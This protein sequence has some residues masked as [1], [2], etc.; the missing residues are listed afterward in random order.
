MSSEASLASFSIMPPR[1]NTIG[2][3][4]VFQDG[5]ASDRGVLCDITGQSSGLGGL[6]GER[7]DAD[8]NIFA[9][10]AA[11]ARASDPDV[12]SAVCGE[13]YGF[14]SQLDAL[15]SRQ[16]RPNCVFGRLMPCYHPGPSLA[17][18]IVVS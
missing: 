4:A 11:G 15:Q 16:G 6:G 8:V 18:D 12:V 2:R 3:K 1:E 5:S 7:D 13:W 17:A 14:Y 10:E 9:V